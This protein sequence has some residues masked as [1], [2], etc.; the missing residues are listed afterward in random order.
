MSAKKTILILCDWFL[1]GYLAGG[2]IQ[3]IATLTKQLGDE[4]N[5]KIITTDRDFKS[6]EGYKNITTNTW[7]S[8]EG[9]TVF[10]VSP[11]NMNPKFI[12][13]LIQSTDF[14]K[15]YLN[16]LFS[17]L[18]T[19][20]P[21]KWKQQGKIHQQVVLAPRGMLRD[22]A[23][24]VKPFKKQ[25]YL[26]YAKFTG[27][28]KNV[29]WQSTSSQETVEIKKRIGNH[30]QV[31]EVSNLPAIPGDIISIDKQSGVLKLCFIARIVDIKNLYFAIDALKAVK[32]HV[33]FDVYGPKED[34][35]Y[36]KQCEQNAKSLPD[37]VKFT[38]KSV[39]TPEDIGNTIGRY[40][41]LLLPTQTE[42][43]GHIIAETFQNGRP[44]IISDQTP[45]R[46]LT[47]ENAGF[48]LD[49]TDKKAFT[50]AIEKIASLNQQEFD[51]VCKN[52]LLFIQRKLNIQD[53]KLNYLNLFN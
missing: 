48:D 45:W 36:W 19:V 24:A 27:L 14:D 7:T 35:A 10:Y 21:L 37:N 1:P 25:L 16:S 20:Y 51:A 53:I 29:S 23:L 46:N 44:V 13:N 5:F 2:P 31:S 40:H 47:N 18:F 8:Y 26:L 32:V 4:I 11:E 6:N 42:N 28:F 39:L 3:S 30:A 15:I 22:G 12:L 9:R 34:E 43:F 33:V 41:A 49:L 50:V 38:Y 17:K 52:C